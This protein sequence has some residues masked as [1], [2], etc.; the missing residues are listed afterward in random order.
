MNYC[1][2]VGQMVRRSVLYL[3][4]LM[5]EN[6]TKTYTLAYDAPFDGTLEKQLGKNESVLAL[7]QLK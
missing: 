2:N 7:M 4:A 3:T 1:P 6:S 5:K